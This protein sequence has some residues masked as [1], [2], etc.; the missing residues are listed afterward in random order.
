MLF[1]S[2]TPILV[3][4][5]NKMKAYEDCP[6]LNM[7]IDTKAKMFSNGIWK[8][9]DKNDNEVKEHDVLK[10]LYKPNPLQNNSKSWLMLYSLSYDIFSNQFIRKLKAFKKDELPKVLYILPSQFMTVEPTGKIYSQTKISDIIKGYQLC[11]TGNVAMSGYSEK[12]E[13]DDIIYIA[14]NRNPI[15]GVSKIG[16]LT[17]PISNIVATLKSRNI[18]ITEKG[19]FGILSNDS[20]DV[21]AVPIAD[22]ER[23]QI[24]RTFKSDNDLY[25]EESKIVLTNAK[26]KWQPIS[27]PM[28]DMMY[29]EEIEDDVAAI[30]GEFGMDRDIFPSTKGA[31]FENKLQGLKSTYQNTIIPMADE[32]AETLTNEFALNEKGLKLKLCYDH[33][34]IMKE[35]ELKEAQAELTETQRLSLLKRD[36]IISAETYAQEAEIE[37]TGTGISEPKSTFNVSQN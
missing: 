14:Q 31:T 7:V 17:L 22:G 27:F 13:V 15:I 33:L 32:L 24:R 19:I 10:L 23:N 4:V 20:S 29:F 3:D 21:D 25:N 11:Y 2:K 26:L 6:H 5:S 30:C 18:V 8:L 16:S 1:R 34:P 28:K 37:M 12:F 36:G 9:Y 35:D